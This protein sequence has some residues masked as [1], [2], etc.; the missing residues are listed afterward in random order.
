MKK[1]SIFLSLLSFT[2]FSQAKTLADI[3]YQVINKE[4][5]VAWHGSP[6]MGVGHDGTIQLTSG[7]LV[8][9]TNGKAKGGTFVMNMKSINSIDEKSGKTNKGLVEHLNDDD[10]FSTMRFPTATFLITKIASGTKPNEYTITGNMTIKGISNVI[11][12]PAT[13]ATE[14]DRL[15]AQATIILNRTLWGITYKSY[16]F[17]AQMKD[18]LI[19]NDIKLSLSLVLNKSL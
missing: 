6:I 5:Q 1:L 16:N 10:F 12:F 11:T 8:I 18:D 15:K 17:L 4:S 14:N 2:A 19:S 9:A 7:T 13:I 3:T